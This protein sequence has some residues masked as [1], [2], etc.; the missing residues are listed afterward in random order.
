[1]FMP[2]VN[3]ERLRLRPFPCVFKKRPADP[4]IVTAAHRQPFGLDFALKMAR[5]CYFIAMDAQGRFVMTLGTE[6]TRAPACHLRMGC[7]STS[8]LHTYKDNCMDVQDSGTIRQQE[9][10]RGHLLA[11]PHYG[12]GTVFLAQPGRYAQ[13]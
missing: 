4:A 9:N 13:C 8:D 7:H 10:Q 3:L 5:R 6:C 11:G 2:A 1:M 12:H